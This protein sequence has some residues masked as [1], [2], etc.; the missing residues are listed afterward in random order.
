MA[1]A[2]LISRRS[3]GLQRVYLPSSFVRRN[4][5]KKRLKYLIGREEGGFGWTHALWGPGLGL[6]DSGFDPS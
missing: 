5:A 3:S 1:N 6:L 4:L 2:E